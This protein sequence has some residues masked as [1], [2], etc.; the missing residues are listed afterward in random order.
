MSS[1]PAV[2]KRI[3][4]SNQGQQT[5]T[6]DQRLAPEGLTTQHGEE[7]GG[8]VGF[9]RALDGLGATGTL[10]S[11]REEAESLPAEVRSI[12]KKRLKNP[13]F[14]ARFVERI[15]VY[16]ERLDVA[17]RRFFLS[18]NFFKEAQ[19]R[20]QD[21]GVEISRG[22][23]PGTDFDL[24]FDQKLQVG[25]FK[26]FQ[27]KDLGTLDVDNLSDDA[28]GWL[29]PSFTW[30]AAAFAGLFEGFP[31]HFEHARQ[32]QANEFFQHFGSLQA[33][34]VA[35]ERLQ[36]LES[37]PFF[38][39]ITMVQLKEILKQVNSTEK[40]VLDIFVLVL[41]MNDRTE[42]L[43]QKMIEASP[44]NSMQAEREKNSEQVSSSASSQ[45]EAPQNMEQIL[46]Q[47]TKQ[48]MESRGS[49]SSV[50]AEMPAD[51]EQMMK[52][53]VAQQMMGP[54][55]F[56]LSEEQMEQAQRMTKQMMES[57]GSS[58]SVGAEM[59]AVEQ[60]SSSSSSQPQTGVPGD[61]VEF[62]LFMM[63]EIGFE[64]MQKQALIL[65]KM[66]TV[67]LSKEDKAFMREMERKISTVVYKFFMRKVAP[68]LP[69][70]DAFFVLYSEGHWQP[71]D[72][73]FL[74]C[75]Q[76]ALQITNA[77]MFNCMQTPYS[78]LNINTPFIEIVLKDQYV[79]TEAQ[80]K[81]LALVGFMLSKAV[82]KR[83][84]D[85][86]LRQPSVLGLI[87]VALN[88][89]HK[90][91]L[92]AYSHL[93][94]VRWLCQKLGIEE[95]LTYVEF[96]RH[97]KRAALDVDKA[98]VAVANMVDLNPEGLKEKL[99]AQLGITEIQ[100]NALAKGSND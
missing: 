85:S 13:V 71:R 100:F 98:W 97:A 14:R 1:L 93:Q 23:E 36:E 46:S 35:P 90:A 6:E 50:G 7:V 11:V 31:E 25:V 52:S 53:K 42:K 66:M 86:T 47:M 18:G 20:I 58:S 67:G 54:S 32:E 75:V 17:R 62:S 27:G 83:K 57:R 24:V 38:Q 9:E 39:L 37:N 96:S 68:K 79:D 74:R 26:E 65:A 19:T 43:Q 60:V 21:S 44:Q 49:S 72:I 33:S 81:L 82:E 41:E 5:A 34:Q 70:H 61:M 87:D 55:G 3:V 10:E 95:A 91:L 2:T 88:S 92:H 80:T 94:F 16:S 48:M 22:I 40:F 77:E 12:A 59:P 45:T 51:L 69:E 76:G 30:H 4:N 99:C 15:K 28:L 29:D 78:E 8:G 56:N 64:Q 84:T 73:A 89:E 63:S